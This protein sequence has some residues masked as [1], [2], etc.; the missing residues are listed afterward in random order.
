MGL[1]KGW[2][3][4]AHSWSLNLRLLQTQERLEQ[5]LNYPNRDRSRCYWS[6]EWGWVRKR[7]WRAEW[8]VVNLRNRN[9]DTA[10]S[11]LDKSNWLEGNDCGEKYLDCSACLQT[12]D[13]TF[14]VQEECVPRN[15]Q[16]DIRACHIK[17]LLARPSLLSASQ[18]DLHHHDDV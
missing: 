6:V 4:H 17:L 15:S 1:A 7:C 8:I 3:W 11:Q 5:K 18:Y 16:P 9:W 10:H 2:S 14:I 12:I 13:H